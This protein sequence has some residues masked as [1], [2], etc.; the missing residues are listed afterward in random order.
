[1]VEKLIKFISS[2]L[3]FF[4]V[5]VVLIV[6]MKTGEMFFTKARNEL[7]VLVCHADQIDNIE[8]CKPLR[9]NQ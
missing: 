6:G 4:F 8:M 2:G 3:Y 1:M 7:Y 5:G 9:E